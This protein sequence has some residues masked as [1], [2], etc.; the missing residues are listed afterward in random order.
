MYN[1]SCAGTKGSQ[2]LSTQHDPD[3]EPCAPPLDP[4]FF[5]FDCTYHPR[6]I[7]LRCMLSH[8]RPQCTKTTSAANS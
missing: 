3:D 2:E 8:V 5:E 7:P 6:P 4:E 1:L